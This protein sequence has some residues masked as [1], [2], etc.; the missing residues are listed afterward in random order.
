MANFEDYSRIKNITINGIS[1]WFDLNYYDMPKMWNPYAK[2]TR[3]NNNFCIQ[4]GK[5]VIGGIDALITSDNGGTYQMFTFSENQSHIRGCAFSA[6]LL[7]YGH[8]VSS[9]TFIRECVLSSTGLSIYLQP[10]DNGIICATFIS[11]TE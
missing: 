4:Y 1:H 11:F 5:I 2:M 6:S 7:S 10:G 9:Q 3:P 8:E